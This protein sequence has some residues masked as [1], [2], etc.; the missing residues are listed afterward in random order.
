MPRKELKQVIVYVKE[1]GENCS[2]AAAQAFP[3]QQ[4]QSGTFG[5]MICPIENTTLDLKAPSA[6]SK[7][8]NSEGL[9][10]KLP[11]AKRGCNT[12][13]TLP[14]PHALGRDGSLA[15]ASAPAPEAPAAIVDHVPSESDEYSGVGGERASRLLARRSAEAAKQA[16]AEA[17]RRPCNTA[18]AIALH[19]EGCQY[20]REGNDASAIVAYKNAGQQGYGPSLAAAA[21]LVAKTEAD[22]SAAVVSSRQRC[23]SRIPDE[24]V[25]L[26]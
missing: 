11:E 23:P 8:V 21:L 13:S 24:M 26:W 7:R 10:A 4:E 17:V 12:P 2:H 6:A 20:L 16:L 15:D 22:F 25:T 19:A 1:E 18:S 9:E 3:T 5:H 14:P